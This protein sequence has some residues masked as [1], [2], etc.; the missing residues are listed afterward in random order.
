MI[1]EGAFLGFLIRKA[2]FIRDM[3]VFIM[4]SNP[5]IFFWKSGCSNREEFNLQEICLSFTMGG[6][7]KSISPKKF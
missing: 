2:A 3:T 1:F 4:E 5:N 7:S 6:E